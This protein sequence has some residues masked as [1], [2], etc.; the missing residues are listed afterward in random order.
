MYFRSQIYLNISEKLLVFCVT[1]FGDGKLVCLFFPRGV[2]LK[3]LFFLRPQ[4]VTNGDQ[5]EAGD[6]EADVN[7]EEKTL[8]E[9]C[10]AQT[11]SPE[12]RR[13]LSRRKRLDDYILK[14]KCG[15]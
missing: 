13:L 1:W 2:A 10:G 5:G 7:I 14:I 4:N 9:F 3:L 11:L 8:K 6:G 15:K 12:T